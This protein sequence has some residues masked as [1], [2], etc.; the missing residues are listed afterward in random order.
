MGE[1]MSNSSTLQRRGV[2]I[3]GDRIA[4]FCRRWKVRRL[5]LFGSYLRDDFHAGSDVDF[6]YDFQPDARWGLED[7]LTME[8]D[9]ASI[10]GRDVDLVPRRAI[11]SGR[12]YI[13]RRHILTTAEPIYVE[14]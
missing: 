7:L 12:N 13:R 9:L 4:E 8:E 2:T 10:V 3:A 1:P 6:L 11:E 5:D 14:G